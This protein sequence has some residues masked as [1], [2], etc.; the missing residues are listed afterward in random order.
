MKNMKR[1]INK[2]TAGAFLLLLPFSALLFTGCE[3]DEF[4]YQDTDKI[5]LSG[6]PAQQATSDSTLVTFALEDKTT[7]T[8]D[9][10]I[11]ANLTGAM[12]DHDRSFKLVVVDSLTNVSSDAY[13]LGTCVLPANQYKVTVPVKVKRTVSGIDL[14]KNFAKVTFRVVD[15]S[16]LTP[17]VDDRLT[18]SVVWCD[19]LIQPESW[20]VISYYLGSFT[21]ARYRFIIDQTG[22]TDFSAYNNNYS[23]IIGF[24]ALMIRLLQDWNNDPA[25][26][27]SEYGWPYLNDN[28]QPL[29]YGQGV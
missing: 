2:V 4:Y 27:N 14:K 11:I 12:S 6:D 1:Y 16:E 3:N 7:T 13:E 19:Y 17:S 9:V 8:L 28:G 29:K 24:Q 22:M 21:Q 23:W 20:S 5:W 26:A 10:N 18:Y 25:N 15:D